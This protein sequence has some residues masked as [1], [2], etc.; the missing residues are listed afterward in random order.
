[1]S[2]K[3]L[4]ATC[5]WRSRSACVRAKNSDQC[6]CPGLY[7]PI[8]EATIVSSNGTPSRAFEAA[9]KSRSVFGENREPPAARAGL[10]ERRGRLREGR[11]GRQRPRER[12]GLTVGEREVFA[13]GEPLQR[14]RQHGAVAPFGILGLHLGLELVVALEQPRQRP[15]PKS[16]ASSP[17]IPPFQSISVP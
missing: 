14:Q 2:W 10:L 16:R 7:E 17:P 11:P 12:V 1:M 9:M 6:R 5:T 3:R 13:C 8:S 4:A 15:S